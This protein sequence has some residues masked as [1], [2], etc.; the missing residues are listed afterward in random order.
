MMDQLIA[1]PNGESA[2]FSDTDDIDTDV[3]TCEDCL[4]DRIETVL[5]IILDDMISD[6]VFAILDDIF[7]EDSK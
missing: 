4:F 5:D 7:G 6:R 1:L 3:C 2:V